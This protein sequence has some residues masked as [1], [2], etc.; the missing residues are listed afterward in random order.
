M[1]GLFDW[2]ITQKKQKKMETN[3]FTPKIDSLFVFPLDLVNYFNHLAGIW[4]GGICHK[5]PFKYLFFV[6]VNIHILY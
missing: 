5:F 3:L 2:L 1:L 6:L 4:G